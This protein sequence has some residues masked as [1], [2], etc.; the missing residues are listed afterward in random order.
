MSQKNIIKELVGLQDVIVEQV[1]E[2]EK[3]MALSIKVCKFFEK[4]EY[5]DAMQNGGTPILHG[6]G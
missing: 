2:T 3:E 1:E 4:V 5:V 6:G